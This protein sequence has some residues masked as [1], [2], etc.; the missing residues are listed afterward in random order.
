VAKKGVGLLPV[1]SDSR[2]AAPISVGPYGP[3]RVN[4]LAVAATQPVQHSLHED[5]QS[6]YSRAHLS[7]GAMN[8]RGMLPH[9][10]SP[11]IVKPR[12]QEQPEPARQ[13]QGG[14]LGNGHHLAP[15][16]PRGKARKGALAH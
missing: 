8:A 15:Q 10:A 3:Q 2:Y 11:F 12:Q 7:R 9:M 16:K 4:P 13:D 5:A 14:L 1:P 6:Q